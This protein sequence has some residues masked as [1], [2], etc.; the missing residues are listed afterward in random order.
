MST[1]GQKRTLQSVRTMSALP[2]KADMVRHG[3]DVRSLPVSD[4]ARPKRN[5]YAAKGPK[6]FRKSDDAIGETNNWVLANDFMD[7]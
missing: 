2:L 6:Y 7:L 1:L 5:R 3:S 4:M